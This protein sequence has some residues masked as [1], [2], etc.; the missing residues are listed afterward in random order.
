MKRVSAVLILC[1]LAA[2]SCLLAASGLELICDSRT[3][4]NHLMDGDLQKALNIREE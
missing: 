3:I 4:A 1:L 2:P